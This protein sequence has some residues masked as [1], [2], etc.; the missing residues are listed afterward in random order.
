MTRVMGF[1]VLVGMMI[2]G[3]MAQAQTAEPAP[4]YDLKGLIDL[5]MKT[6]I[7]SLW[8]AVGPLA[9]A[10]I[11]KIVNSMSTAYVPR[12]IQVI[13]SS[14]VSAIGAGL[15]GDISMVTGAAMGAQAQLLAATQPKTLLTEAKAD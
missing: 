13:L 7:P 14:I 5:A 1:F 3:A 2:V 9:V 6:L 15:S 4:T 8:V 12:S 11:T 10:G